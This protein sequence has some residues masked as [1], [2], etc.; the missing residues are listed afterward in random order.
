MCACL[1][2]H[3]QQHAQRVSFTS[4]DSIAEL[5]SLLLAGYGNGKKVSIRVD[6]TG[7]T[8]TAYTLSHLGALAEVYSNEIPSQVRAHTGGLICSARGRL[9]LVPVLLPV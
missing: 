8:P 2:T 6:N 5:R 4:F 9:A 1:L 3:R 7:S